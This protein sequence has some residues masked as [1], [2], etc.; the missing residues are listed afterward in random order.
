MS[1]LIDEITYPSGD[2]CIFLEV[3]LGA[4][5][6]LKLRDEL[7]KRIQ[8][9]EVLGKATTMGAKVGVNIINRIQQLHQEHP[10]WSS[11]QIAKFIGIHPQTVRKYC[12]EAKK[13]KKVNNPEIINSVLT[14]RKRFPYLSTRQI[15]MESEHDISKTTVEN[16]LRI[17]LN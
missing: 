15:A 11:Y 4:E 13:I 16:I 9:F 2:L 6:V 10:E 14:L 17:H 3:K 5:G 8:R 12:P 7:R 1:K